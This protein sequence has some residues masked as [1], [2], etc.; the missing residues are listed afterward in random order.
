MNAAPAAAQ[1]TAK[2]AA[3]SSA[4]GQAAESITNVQTAGFDE[5]GIVK[6]ASAITW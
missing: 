1:A 5:G 3:D 2:A 4:V 6:R